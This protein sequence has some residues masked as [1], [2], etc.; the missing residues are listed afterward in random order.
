MIYAATIDKQTYDITAREWGI[1]AEVAEQVYTYL[2]QN[3]PS[4]KLLEKAKK[5]GINR[6]YLDW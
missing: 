5:K 4:P 6:I 2:L 1:S 3:P